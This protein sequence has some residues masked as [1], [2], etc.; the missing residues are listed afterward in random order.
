MNKEQ[1]I[2]FNNT[3]KDIILYFDNFYEQLCYIIK[4]Y[5]YLYKSNINLNDNILNNN[6]EIKYSINNNIKK[7]FKK[8]FKNQ[9][10]KN[11]LTSKCYTKY[12]TIYFTIYFFYIETYELMIIFYTFNKNNIYTCLFKFNASRYKRK[13]SIIKNKNNISFVNCFYENKS[14]LIKNNIKITNYDNIINI[15]KKY[16]YIINRN[17]MY[18]DIDFMYKEIDNMC[19]KSTYKSIKYYDVK[20]MDRY[21]DYNEIRINIYKNKYKIYIFIY[22]F[23]RYFYNIK[24]DLYFNNK[25]LYLIE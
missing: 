8:K 17:K 4:I 12:K 22:R 20:P 13:L 6:I 14:L 19:Y 3:F 24:L 11:N 7:K 25:L 9:I 5:N 16:N 23:D 21:I 15:T 18:I 1:L 2:F 10:I